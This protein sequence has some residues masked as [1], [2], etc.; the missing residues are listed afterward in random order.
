VLQLPL[1]SGRA[2]NA[3]DNAESPRV[4][5]INE[6]MARRLWPEG[7][8]LGR[9]FRFGAERVTIIGVAQDAKYDNL[10]EKTPPYVYFASAQHWRSDQW[11][12][13]Q[14]AGDAAQLAS[15]IEGAVRA[16]DPLLPRPVV[17]TLTQTTSIALLPQRVAA[18]VTGVLGAVGLLLATVGLYGLI[19]YSANR[20]T[21]EIGIRMALG[22]RRSDV[23]ALVVR[24]GIWLAGLGVVIG[25]VLAGAASQ[26][27]RNLLFDTSPIDLPTYAVM[28]LL[29][30]AVAM[31]ASY[32]PARR[33]ASANPATALRTD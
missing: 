14:T 17:M 31:L 33:A 1:R 6:T 3:T 13:V 22:A 16:I 32:L 20:R 27:L 15:A 11:L 4:A 8:A 10:A 19:A 18:L 28:S 29:F 21:R 30:I 24:E 5:V 7:T 26:L 2:I 9:T 25:V 12:L 23:L